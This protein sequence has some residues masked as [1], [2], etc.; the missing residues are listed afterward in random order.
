M[1]L[2]EPNTLKVR[3]HSITLNRDIA[4]TKVMIAGDWHISPIVSDRQ[5]HYLKEALEATQPDVIILQGDLIDSPTELKRETSLKKLIA[6]LRL[7]VKAAP[8]VLVLGSHD[9]ITPTN[10]ARIMKDFAL[11]FWRKICQKTGVKLLCDEWYETPKIRIFG[12]FQNEKC[13]ITE[14]QKFRDNPRAFYRQV[15]DYDFSPVNDKKINWFAAH[16]PYL[17]KE[18]AE[19]LSIFDILS[20]GHTH[21]GI[22]PKGL[23]EIFAKLHIHRGLISPN[24]MPLPRHSRGVFRTSQSTF[25]LINPGMVGAQFCA[26]KIGQSLNFIKAAEIS[27]VEIKNK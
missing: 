9:Y 12:A 19:K 8:T 27:L 2:H 13:M 21:G 26:P 1:N 7:C 24:R 4:T 11:P 18:T 5:Y 20:F 23:D 14:K 6:S 15:K 3:L 16:A 10:P 22:V 17:I 25:A